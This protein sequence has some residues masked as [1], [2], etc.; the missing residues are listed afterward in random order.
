PIIKTQKDKIFKTNTWY[1]APAARTTP[2]K[3]KLTP[4][5]RKKNAI[6]FK[7]FVPKAIASRSSINNFTPN[8]ANIYIQR[9]IIPKTKKLYIKVYLVTADTR[10][11]FR[12]P[13]F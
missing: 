1:I 10:C 13:I 7:Y 5:K 4:K 12:I 11:Q 9:P 3:I 2:Y 6:I 8:S